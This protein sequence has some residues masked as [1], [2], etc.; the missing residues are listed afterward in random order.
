MWRNLP[1]SFQLNSHHGLLLNADNRHSLPP[2]GKDS[3]RIPHQVL[4][5]PDQPAIDSQDRIPG[6]QPGFAR[7]AVPGTLKRITP[8]SHGVPAVDHSSSP[9]ILRALAPAQ[10]RPADSGVR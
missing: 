4:N 9:V 6:R 7:F 2:A 8:V 10:R 5:V 1:K 3:P